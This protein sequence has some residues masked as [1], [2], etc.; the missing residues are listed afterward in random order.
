MVTNGEVMTQPDKAR[1]AR[2]REQR[3]DRLQIEGLQ[4]FLRRVDAGEY[5]EKDHIWAITELSFN[6]GAALYRLEALEAATRTQVEQIAELQAKL[7]ASKDTAESFL[8]SYANVEHRLIIATERC[9]KLEAL[10][11]RSI[12]KMRILL[13]QTRHVYDGGE[14]AGWLIKDIQKALEVK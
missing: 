14:N 2:Q 8:E 5:N 11:R 6:L 12:S 4:D 3:F 1:E 9:E 10:L 13:E 7:E